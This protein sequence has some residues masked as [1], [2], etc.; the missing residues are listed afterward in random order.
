MTEK[1]IIENIVIGEEI[2]GVIAHLDGQ[3]VSGY[4]FRLRHHSPGKAPEPQQTDWFFVSDQNLM[5]LMA[6]WRGFAENSGHLR[7]PPST[8]AH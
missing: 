7:T 3:D 6:R 1:T 2:R 8:S 5:E 4:Q